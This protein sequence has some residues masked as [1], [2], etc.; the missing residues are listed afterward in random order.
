MI[1]FLELELSKSVVVDSLY[2]ICR[3]NDTS[4]T[5]NGVKYEGSLLCVGNLLMSWSPRKFSEITTDRYLL[6]SL[7]REMFLSNVDTSLTV[8]IRQCFQV[9]DSNQCSVTKSYP[10]ELYL[11]TVFE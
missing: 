7:I 3:F 2:L 1:R 11:T 4:F 8:I 10:F 9:L 6:S 5:V